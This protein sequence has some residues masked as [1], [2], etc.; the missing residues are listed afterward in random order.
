MKDQ[1]ARTSITPL[2]KEYQKVG[3]NHLEKRK[4]A[5]HAVE[6]L[7]MNYS[8]KDQHLLNRDLNTT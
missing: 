5:K 3:L 8:K 4:L 2:Y 6:T 1:V 7:V